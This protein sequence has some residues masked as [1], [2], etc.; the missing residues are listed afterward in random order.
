MSEGHSNPARIWGHPALW[1]LAKLKLRGFVRL[2]VRRVKRPAG[3][4]FFA[5]GLLLAVVWASGFTL[6]MGLVP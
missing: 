6:L 5:I 2:Q 3:M 1:L 4:A